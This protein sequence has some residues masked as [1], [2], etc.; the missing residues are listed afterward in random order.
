MKNTC[1]TRA[2][3]LPMACLFAVG[4]LASNQIFS[5]WIEQG[6]GPITA[7]AVQGIPDRPVS[8]AC[9]SFAFDPSNPDIIYVAATNGGIWKSTNG[10]QSNP[11]WFPLTDLKLPSLSIASLALSPLKPLAIFAGSGSTSSD[12]G[13]GSPGFGVVRSRDGGET[14][15]VLAEETFKDRT[16]ISIVPTKLKKGHVVLA[17]T[18]RDNGGIYRSTDFGKSF[19]RISDNDFSNLPNQGVSS[20]VADPGDSKRFYAAVPSKSGVS[21]GNE[22]IYRSDDGG[23][24][25][26]LMNLG[27]S[28]I[29]LSDRILLAVHNNPIFQTNVVYAMVLGRIPLQSGVR[30]THV[31]RSINGGEL[32]TP[33]TPLPNP[34][35]FP[36]GQGNIHGAIVADPINPN[37]LFIAGDTQIGPFPN[38]N[39]ATGFFANIFRGDVTLLPGNPWQNVIGNG[40]QGTAPHADSRRLTFNPAGNIIYA[41]DGGIYTLNNPN[42]PLTRIWSSYNGNIRPTE[43]HSIA[44]DS[45]SNIIFGGTQDNGT[46]MQFAFGNF[47][48]FDFEGGDGGV[49]AIDDDQIAHPGI[50][51]RYSCVQFFDLVKRSTWDANN[52]FLGVADVGLLIL[53]GPNAGNKLTKANDPDIR[54]YQPY[55]LN[56]VD[57]KR[58]LIGTSTIYESLDNGDTLQ[59][60]LFPLGQFTAALTYGGR[61]NGVD[62]PDVFYLGTTTQ[63]GNY[64]FPQIVHRV[65]INGPI[66]V[67]TNYPGNS[68]T[69]IAMDP[70]NY[71]HVYVSD[72]LGKIWT[73]LDEGVTWK[74]LTFNLPELTT[75]VEVIT[76]INAGL[77]GKKLKLLVGGLGGV[78]KL[79]KMHHHDEHKHKHRECSSSSSKEI[80]H[81][82]IWKKFGKNLPHALVADLHYNYTD[83]LLV[84]GTLGRGAWTLSKPS[85]I[86]KGGKAFEA[87]PNVI[88]ADFGGFEEYPQVP[89][90]ARPK[91]VQSVSHL[92]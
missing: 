40:A 1:F 42:D 20:L 80:A 70:Q 77:N 27:L 16:I 69:S 91:E 34:E 18:F 53:N 63:G 19:D 25:W 62:V 6:P 4:I 17:A 46:P 35:I 74:N 87:N 55:V 64:A 75:D 78:F 56:N 86:T 32:W 73:S 3:Y 54:F 52:N 11:T 51:Y 72:T 48:W 30:L 26:G 47:T 66:T 68:V 29:S 57:P 82:Y 71:R 79:D 41:C 61:I 84:A 38:V 37:V 22:G 76:V 15:Q 49:V 9:N 36:G 59:D 8:G 85:L 67:L 24:T 31:F 44:Y 13:E 81:K 88:K 5:D 10:T 39:G 2:S 92:F 33:I 60:L 7:A 89:A 45:L 90:E 83:N 50:S 58:M 43:F 14:W 12:A 21:T 23:L 28:G 65:N